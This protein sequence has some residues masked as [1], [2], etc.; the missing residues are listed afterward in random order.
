MLFQG[1]ELTS[2]LSEVEAGHHSASPCVVTVVS[3]EVKDL[4]L[5]QTLW[6]L[7]PL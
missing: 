6:T 4:N 5:L 1:L 3:L 7:S 2:W